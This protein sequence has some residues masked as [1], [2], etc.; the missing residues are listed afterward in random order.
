MEIKA[1]SKYDWETI[2][3]LNKF[4]FFVRFRAFTIIVASAFVLYMLTIVGRIPSIILFT[5]FYGFSLDYIQDIVFYI[6]VMA[7]WLFWILA[8]PKI[9]YNRRKDAKNCENEF[10]FTEQ[11]IQ[12]FQHKEL[13]NSSTEILYSAIGRVY[14][15]KDFIYIY[16]I[17]NKR[18]A[19]I[20]DKST[21]C[22][23]TVEE[24][25]NL[26]I[27]KVGADKY[28]LKCKV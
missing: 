6:I 10:V 4:H 24:L 26:F 22:D 27:S 11:K 20:V 13:I 25:R 19:Y 9:R 3:K 5:K 15:V 8:M 28:K 7:L 18:G 1:S 2:K 14:E 16:L 23:G 21:V 17:D 12:L